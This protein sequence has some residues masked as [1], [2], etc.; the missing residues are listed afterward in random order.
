[1]LNNLKNVILSD[2]L[3][4]RYKFPSLLTHVYPRQNM[5]GVTTSTEGITTIMKGVATIMEGVTT[6][7]TLV[8]ISDLRARLL[9]I[10]FLLCCYFLCNGVD[11]VALRGKHPMKMQKKT[12]SR[13]VRSYDSLDMSRGNWSGGAVWRRKS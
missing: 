12:L 5:K 3:P 9:W 7:R 13:W 4:E 11:L 6:S 2:H 1:M 8:L 10:V